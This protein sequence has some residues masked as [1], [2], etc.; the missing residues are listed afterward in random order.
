MNDVCLF[1]YYLLY[2][3]SNVYSL[4]LCGKFNHRSTK[5]P[6][7]E[8]I[9]YNEPRINE[10]KTKEKYE[11]L[12]IFYIRRILSRFIK[13]SYI[14]SMI[15]YFSNKKT[16]STIKHIVAEKFIYCIRETQMDPVSEHLTK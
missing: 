8:N 7:F 10:D 6:K 15:E 12:G 16:L 4:K 2:N 13:C 5:N 1:N 11:F 3:I 9:F 14:E